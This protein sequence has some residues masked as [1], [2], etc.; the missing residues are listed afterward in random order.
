MVAPGDTLQKVPNILGREFG[1]KL[2]PVLLPW[3]A[4][5]LGRP[6]PSYKLLFVVLMVW[7]FSLAEC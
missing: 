1:K 3:L 7:R 5:C 6:G 4:D 2:K